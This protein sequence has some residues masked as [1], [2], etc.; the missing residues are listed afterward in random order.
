M[1]TREYFFLLFPIIVSQFV[2]IFQPNKT[3]PFLSSR[4]SSM[5]YIEISK[6]VEYLQYNL[7][8]STFLYKDSR[9]PTFIE[10]KLTEVDK[11]RKNC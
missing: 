3:I 11:K 5:F 2:P 4:S 7:F 10:K 6:S 8:V 9:C 1:Q